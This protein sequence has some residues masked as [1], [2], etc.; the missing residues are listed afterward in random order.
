MLKRF[1][2]DVRIL[3]PFSDDYENLVFI[4]EA[5]HSNVVL[6][7]GANKGTFAADLFRAGYSGSVVSFEPLPDAYQQLVARASSNARWI[8]APMIALGESERIANFHVAGNGSSSSL[9]EMENLH[10]DVAPQSRVVSSIPVHV[11]RLDVVAPELIG[12]ADNIF[13]KIDTQGYEDAVI[14]GATGILDRVVAIR[15]EISFRPLYKG[16]KLFEEMISKITVMG[17]ELWE[18]TPVLRDLR[19]GQMLQCDA[20][21][22]R[23]PKNKPS[24]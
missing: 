13:L 12:D 1:G 21:F 16:Q 8:V 6:D 10:V 11:K 15:T 17:F 14:D 4:S 19:T 20:T 22:V 2:L 23:L 3:Q 7:V 9:L 5:I 18:I 24:A